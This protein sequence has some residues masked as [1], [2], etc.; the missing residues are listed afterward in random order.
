MNALRCLH[1]YRYNGMW[2][3]D[4]EAVGLNRE[5]FVCGVPEVFDQLLLAKGITGDRFNL[6]FGE[7]KFPGHDLHATWVREESGGNWYATSIGE[8]WLCPAMFNYY[9]QA[10]RDIYFSIQSPVKG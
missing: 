7:S 5:P 10:P 2:V 8:G 9:D 4:D 1:V 3:F 6:L